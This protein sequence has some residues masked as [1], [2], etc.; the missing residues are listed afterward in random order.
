MAY[1]VLVS[2]E[3]LGDLD[4]IVGFIK[5][6][7]SPDAARNWLQSILETIG[8]LSVMPSRCPL[9][10]EAADLGDPVRLLLHGRRNRMFQI[11]FLIVESKASRT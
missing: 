10:P 1:E 4:A 5:E 7:G 9:A 2:D 8:S 3:A 6:Q 11:F